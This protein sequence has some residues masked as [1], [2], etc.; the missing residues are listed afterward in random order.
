MLVDRLDEL[1][2][3]GVVGFKAFMCPTGI[4]DFR[5]ADDDTLHAGMARAARLGLPVAVH[6]ESAELT[7]RLAAE[8]VSAGRTSMRDY[9]ASR[10]VAA[11]PEAIEVLS[12]HRLS[13]FV[14]RPL[15]GRIERTILRGSTVCLGG[16]MVASPGGRMV[17]PRFGLSTEA[18]S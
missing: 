12:L 3:R 17:R 1:A 8:A 14:G 5:A 15:R 4:D 9:L 6:A 10:P 16:D 13:P 11:E 2:D 7:T 18:R